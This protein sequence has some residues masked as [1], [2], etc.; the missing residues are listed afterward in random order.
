V[1]SVG[2]CDNDFFCSE[3]NSTLI[4]GLGR[5]SDG[6]PVPL[7]VVNVIFE[8]RSVLYFIKCPGF[9]LN[10][11]RYG[12]YRLRL[13]SISCDPSFIFSI[14]SH[15][16]TVIEVEGTNVKPL[17]V[18]SLEI[19]AGVCVDYFDFLVV[20]I[21]VKTGQRYSVVVCTFCSPFIGTFI[22]TSCSSPPTSLLRTTV[23]F[24]SL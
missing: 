13:I 4:N 3:Y 22:L 12:S 5:Y 7:A 14:D 18:D 17:V 1:A 11:L 19:F 9:F 21:D 15:T 23:S 8:R 2:N 16:L 20:L 10:F 24:S 6:P